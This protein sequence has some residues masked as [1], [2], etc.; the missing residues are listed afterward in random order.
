MIL[1]S[2]KFG[3]NQTKDLEVGPDRWTD[4]QDDGHIY[5]SAQIT[6]SNSNSSGSVKY[7]IRP[8]YYTLIKE[9]TGT[10]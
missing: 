4:R 8:N 1:N 9:K 5:K 2:T 10:I 6:F 3:G 7:L